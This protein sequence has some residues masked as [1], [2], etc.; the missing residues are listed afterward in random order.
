MKP[1]FVCS[2]WEFPGAGG[3]SDNL[4][5]KDDPQNFIKLMQD[6]RRHLERRDR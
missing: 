5:S 2:D 1:S 3:D 4:R 6:I